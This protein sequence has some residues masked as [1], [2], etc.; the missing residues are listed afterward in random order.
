MLRA[1]LLVATCHNRPITS[2]SL[3]EDDRDAGG[4]R[5]LA[6]GSGWLRVNLDLD[7][8]KPTGDKDEE[9]FEFDFSDTLAEVDGDIYAPN[10]E[11]DGENGNISSEYYDKISGRNWNEVNNGDM[12]RRNNLE[13]AVLMPSQENGMVY[14]APSHEKGEEL[15]DEDRPFDLEVGLGAVLSLLCLF[16]VLFLAN[17]L[18]CVLRDLR[19]RKGIKTEECEETQETNSNE[20]EEQ[21]NEKEEMEG[22]KAESEANI[23]GEKITE[24]PKEVEIMC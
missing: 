3:H 13:R 16:T 15:W 22:N 9:E 1:E 17:C 14:F 24:S 11:E 10:F 4:L 18:P 7:F 23:D 8:I 20:G 21:D 2:N 19:K 6:R 12:I 5:R